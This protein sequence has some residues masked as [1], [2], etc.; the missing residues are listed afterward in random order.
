MDNK[1]YLKI[2]GEGQIPAAYIADA[3]SIINDAYRGLLTL[4]KISK[5]DR[6]NLRRSGFNRGVIVD[7]VDAGSVYYLELKSV[8]LQSPG[9]WEFIGELNPL[10]ALRKY[11]NDRHERI[12]DKEY[13]NNL[14]Q[15][16]LSIENNILKLKLI[17]H[18]IDV[19]KNAGIPEHDIASMIRDYAIIPL[20]K[21]ETLQDK[22]IISKAEISYKNKSKNIESE[23]I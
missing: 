15:E 10:D 22:D 11:L 8:V 18:V 2:Y 4:E 1:A 3:V 16:K 12:K 23:E 14:E 21:L 6:R 9:F 13:R 7:I 19:S 20:L 5:L 17:Q